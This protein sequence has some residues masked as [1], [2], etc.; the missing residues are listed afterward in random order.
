MTSVPI[1]GFFPSSR[2][3]SWEGAALLSQSSRIGERKPIA[4]NRR[5]QLLGPN[6]AVVERALSSFKGASKFASAVSGPNSNTGMSKM[7][8]QDLPGSYE[9]SC[10]TMDKL[11]ETFTT[12]NL[13]KMDVEGAESRSLRA[14]HE[15]LSQSAR[16]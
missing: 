1:R 7:V 8:G 4:R 14:P 9:V 13:I 11:A 12:P 15:S 6:V 3:L 5:A 2:Q 16:S 10:V